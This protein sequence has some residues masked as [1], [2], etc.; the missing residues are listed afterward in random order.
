MF[1]LAAL[2]RVNFGMSPEDIDALLGVPAETVAVDADG[3]TSLRWKDAQ[4]LTLLAGYKDGRMQRKTLMRQS[5]ET[6]RAPGPGE[7]PEEVG[8]Q[9]EESNYRLITAG[10]SVADVNALFGV[11]GQAVSVSGSNTILRW[12][13]ATG[14]SFT[15][16]FEGGKLTRKTGLFVAK[17]EP[18]EG[19]EAKEGEAT[20]DAEG[21]AEGYAE[22]EGA[23]DAEAP[24]EEG[25]IMEAGAQPATPAEAAEPAANDTAAP[26]RRSQVRIARKPPVIDEATGEEKPQVSVNEA[27][28]REAKLPKYKRSLRKG[29]YEVQIVNTGETPMKAG[30]RKDSEGLDL[31][32]PPGQARTARVGRGAYTLY[33]V[34]EDDPNTLHQGPGLNI[35]GAYNTDLQVRVMDTSYSVEGLDQ[36]P[37]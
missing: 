22:G 10:M 1:S 9:L 26:E 28:R 15:A 13:D 7:S 30:L 20:A 23:E 5:P 6:L 17:A 16:R 36:A 27:R 32:V 2:D 19:E 29:D 33:F 35:D 37:Y 18:E 12:V 4:G 21:E 11:E 14:S 24:A 31:T 3:T 34:R 8:P 25:I